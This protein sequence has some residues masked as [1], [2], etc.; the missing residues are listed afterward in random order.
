MMVTSDPEKNWFFTLGPKKEILAELP[1]GNLLFLRIILDNQANKS[2]NLHH[3]INL[4][5]RKLD[6]N[7]QN[8][9][10]VGFYQH[11]GFKVFRRSDVEGKGKPFPILHMVL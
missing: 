1:G 5:A 3:S 2:D 8:Q 4:A 6:L 7:E 9:Q 11:Q 10:G